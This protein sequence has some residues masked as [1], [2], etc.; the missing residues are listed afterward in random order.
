MRIETTPPPVESYARSLIATLDRDHPSLAGLEWGRPL[1]ELA[2]ELAPRLREAVFAPP[3]PPLA[4]DAPANPASRY[5]H[6]GE[7]AAEL[8]HRCIVDGRWVSVGREFPFPDGPDY[9]VSPD[10]SLNTANVPFGE[11]TWQLNRHS[12]WAVISR[13]YMHTG[14]RGLVEAVVGW[15]ERWL[16]QCPPPGFDHNARQGSWRTIEIGI[17]LAQT[18]PRVLAAWQ[19]EPVGDELVWLAWLGSWAEQATF[20]WHYRKAAN[21]LMME[22]AGLLSAGVCL[23]M[24]RDASLWRRVAL[25][26][27]LDEAGRQFHG[28]GHQIEL[29]TGYHM[30]CVN[31]YL[32]AR[33]LLREAGYDAPAALDDVLRRA[34]E[35]MRAMARPD[36]LIF[37][38]QDTTPVR[39][40]DA[41][42]RLPEELQGPHDAWFI[43]GRGQPPAERH[44]LLPHAG[45]VVMRS[46]W[47]PGDVALAF[48]G[49]PYGAAHQ[50][51]DKLGI[52]IVAGGAELIGEAGLV[53]YADS[54]QR[55]Y[56]LSTRAHST[57][58]VD[59][60]DQNRQ[61]N[62]RRD[63]IKLNEPA[64]IEC[65]LQA[66]IPWARARYDQGYGPDAA[67]AVTHTRTV[68]LLDGA[69]IV[70]HDHFL[71]DD[72]A[73]HTA[74]VLFHVLVEPVDSDGPSLVSRGPGPNVGVAAARVG[75]GELQGE[76]VI[77]GDAPD[78]RGWAQR[79]LKE[80]GGTWHLVPRPC[81]TLSA[82]FTGEMEVVTAVRVFAAG[83]RAA[84]PRVRVDQRVAHVDDRTWPLPATSAL[85]PVKDG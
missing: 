65:D 50:H 2:A 64:G 48:D 79:P 54:P 62:Y 72:A 29:S 80:L 28:D 6:P 17:R 15:I 68:A 46:G 30:V 49:G 69:L 81:L 34:Y 27:L 20:V 60:L 9:N 43:A 53:D 40:D 52:Q 61:L 7:T 22:M 45:Y 41:L 38:F 36:G 1:Q 73:E 39:I 18:W 33:A 71:A 56:S 31:Q 5:S 78:L 82:R 37:G 47:S 66:Q 19:R 85:G 57:A 4:P 11:W 12:E 21:W 16:T 67:V 74:E 42:A 55:R 3:C 51:E 24:H 14:E 8:A 23:P 84:A 35:P 32:T 26:V 76:T 25:D 58:L 59:G 70:V 83:E 44:H 77:G 63:A 13:L 75:T 10:P